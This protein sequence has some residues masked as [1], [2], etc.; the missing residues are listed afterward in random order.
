MKILMD[1]ERMKAACSEIRNVCLELENCMMN[2]ES[3]ILSTGQDWQ[4]EAEREFENKIFY[5][6]K[7]YESIL[8]FFRDYADE[9]E[10]IV[11]SYEAVEIKY[12]Q[13]IKSL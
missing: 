4:G 8:K 11:D 9:A 3:L 13:M 5:I 6:R 7:R 12:A 10:E 2:I 1:E